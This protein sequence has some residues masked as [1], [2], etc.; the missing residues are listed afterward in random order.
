MP[1]SHTSMDATIPTL[2]AVVCQ[3]TFKRGGEE[4]GRGH[5]PTGYQS[6]LRHPKH[7][8]SRLKDARAQNGKKN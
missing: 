7:K 2:L 3:R 8:E 4:C 5:S 1:L 6:C